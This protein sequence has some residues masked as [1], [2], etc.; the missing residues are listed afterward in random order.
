MPAGLTTHSIHPNMKVYKITTEQPLWTGTKIC[1]G[2]PW[3]ETNN[4]W[5]PTL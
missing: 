5:K 2:G 1:S 3:Y 4:F